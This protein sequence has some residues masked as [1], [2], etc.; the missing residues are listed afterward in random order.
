MDLPAP[1]PDVQVNWKHLQQLLVSQLP[2]N[3]YDNVSLMMMGWKS[4]QL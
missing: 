2:A 3:P 4:E 1:A